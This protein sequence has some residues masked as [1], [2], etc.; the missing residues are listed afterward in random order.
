MHD[1][2]FDCRFSKLLPVILG[3]GG[4]GQTI[5]ISPTSYFPCPQKKSSDLFVKLRSDLY[6]YLHTYSTYRGVG[7]T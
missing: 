1:V 6:V 5:S 4:G 3:I 2:A 7:K